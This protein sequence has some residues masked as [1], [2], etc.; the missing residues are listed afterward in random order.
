VNFDGY[1]APSFLAA[2]E[3][4]KSAWNLTTMSKSYNMAGW[5]IGFCAGNAEMIKAL[6]TIKDITITAFSH[7]FNCQHHRHARARRRSRRT[8]QDLPASPDV[9]CRD[10]I[11][12]VDL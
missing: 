10:W 2:K 7:R 6:A 1:H 9:V 3:P 11:S 5:R 4:R 12:L 8:K